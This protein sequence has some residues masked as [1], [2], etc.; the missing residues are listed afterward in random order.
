MLIF[1]NWLLPSYLNISVLASDGPTQGMTHIQPPRR[2]SC[3]AP[4]SWKKSCNPGGEERAWQKAPHYSSKWCQIQHNIAQ[5]Q[6]KT[7]YCH[8]CCFRLFTFCHGAGG[9]WHPVLDR[10]VLWLGRMA[11]GVRFSSSHA[12]R[13]FGETVRMHFG[14]R[15]SWH[16]QL[17][18]TGR[19][20]L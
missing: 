5:L 12:D 8:I 7:A 14:G 6:F 15:T 1:P 11:D 13:A 9:G 4:V 20:F 18:P 3:W 2:C 16:I 17:D 10:L 19:R